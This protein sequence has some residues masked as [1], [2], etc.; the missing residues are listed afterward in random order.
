MSRAYMQQ[1]Q[2][3]CTNGMTP[4]EVQFLFNDIY[5]KANTKKGKQVLRLFSKG[6]AK[7]KTNTLTHQNQP[8]EN[9]QEIQKDY[10]YQYIKQ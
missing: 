10:Q 4:G 9:V 6:I 2:D 8:L 5:S 7:A 3:A 1:V